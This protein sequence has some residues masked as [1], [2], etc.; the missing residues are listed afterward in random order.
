MTKV[1]VVAALVGL[2]ACGSKAKPAAA[3]STATA[4]AAPAPAPAPAAATDSTAKVAGDTAKK[5]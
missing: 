4:A 3:D 1:F 2:A 5:P